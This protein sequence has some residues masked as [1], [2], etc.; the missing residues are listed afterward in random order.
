MAKLL[1]ITQVYENYAWNEDGSLGTG[2]NAY[3]KAKGGSD[4]VVKNFR[5]FDR[6]VETVNALRPQIEQDNDAFREHII[7]WEVVADDYLTDF[8][9]SQWEYEGKIT[10]PAIELTV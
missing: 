8:E 5:D 4:Y 3:W 10:Y 2:D 7:G 9:R 6:V 1:I